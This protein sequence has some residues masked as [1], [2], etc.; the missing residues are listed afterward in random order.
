MAGVIVPGLPK[1]NPGLGLA[2]TF[3]VKTV[4]RKQEMSLAL[5]GCF[6]FGCGSAAV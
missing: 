5:V 6:S 2:N 3:G 1:L 4:S